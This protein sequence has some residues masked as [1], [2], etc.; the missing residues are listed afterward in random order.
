MK[1]RD[2]TTTPTL[3]YESWRPGVHEARRACVYMSTWRRACV[4]IQNAHGIIPSVIMC[5]ACRYADVR[6]AACSVAQLLLL[7]VGPQ[8]GHEPR[9]TLYVELLKRLDDSSNKVSN[10]LASCQVHVSDDN[11]CVCTQARMMK[12]GSDAHWDSW[13]IAVMTCVPVF[14]RRNAGATERDSGNIST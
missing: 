1:L 13:H 11:L 10:G 7:L 4:Y 5:D 6:S 3:C 14:V 12:F 8:L 2:D 9:R